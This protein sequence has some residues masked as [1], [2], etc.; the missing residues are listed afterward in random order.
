[1]RRVLLAD[2]LAVANW[3]APMPPG[4]RPEALAALIERAHLAHRV[5]RRLGHAHPL[6][7]NGCLAS[8]VAGLAH[9]SEGH[10]PDPDQLESLALVAAA[11]A[12]RQRRAQALREGRG[13]KK[14]PSESECVPSPVGRSDYVVFSAVTRKGRCN[15]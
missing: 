8:A 12:G 15:G 14:A 5:S 4:Q 7:G 13:R 9:R 6:W 10:D 2:L 3:L 11:V 1:M